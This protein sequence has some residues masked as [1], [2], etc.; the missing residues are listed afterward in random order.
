MTDRAIL[1]IAHRQGCDLIVMVTHARRGLD[2]LLHGSHAQGVLSR[3][4]VPL[5]VLPASTRSGAG[6]GMQ[7]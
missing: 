6:S 5:L 4:D 3:S 1:E 7:G 2:R